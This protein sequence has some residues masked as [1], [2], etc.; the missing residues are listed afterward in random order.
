MIKDSGEHCSWTIPEIKKMM[1]ECT[2]EFIEKILDLQ[3]ECP[4]IT[5]AGLKE[6]KYDPKKIAAYERVFKKPQKIDLPFH[7]TTVISVSAI[8]P[9]SHLTNCN[10]S[11]G[12]I[13]GLKVTY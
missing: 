11:V 10:F 7:N 2:A 12:N 9:G 6:E 3:F 13:T 4:R 1:K 8:P 5:I